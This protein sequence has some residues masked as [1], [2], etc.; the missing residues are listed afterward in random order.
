MSRPE[1]I[2][3]DVGPGRIEYRWPLGMRIIRDE[4]RHRR[5]W[6]VHAV[7][8]VTGPH[9]DDDGQHLLARLVQVQQR[10]AV[11]RLALE[12]DPAYIIPVDFRRPCSRYSPRTLAA[13]GSETAATVQ[14]SERPDI[15]AHF[16]LPDGATAL[17]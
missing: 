12:S 8:T 16:V 9:T 1:W 15:A 2:R 13:F 3:R 6:E 14:S 7:L 5:N 11:T 10:R 17:G 4:A